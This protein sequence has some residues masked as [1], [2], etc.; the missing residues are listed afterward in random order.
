MNNIIISQ[1]QYIKYSYY[2][3]GAGGFTDC[4]IKNWKVMLENND[5]NKPIG[6]VRYGDDESA[7]YM[8][9]DSLVEEDMGI[10]LS[11]ES[12]DKLFTIVSNWPI[13]LNTSKPAGPGCSIQEKLILGSKNNLVLGFDNERKKKLNNWCE[14]NGLSLY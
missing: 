2:F 9:D 11:Q 3:S 5:I 6:T 7:R 10:I 1:Y 14:N 13:K 4:N 12:L 8:N